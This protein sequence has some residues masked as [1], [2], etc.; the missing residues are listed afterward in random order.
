MERF[1][2]IQTIGDTFHTANL[3]EG[4]FSYTQ[5]FD[6]KLTG[7]YKLDIRFYDEKTKVAVLV[8]TKRQKS[9]TKKD[10]EQLFAYV[11]LEK[12]L[13]AKT[14]IIAI[15]T[16]IDDGKMRIWKVTTDLV[17]ELDDTK[18]KSFAEYVEYFKPQN[19][20][21]KTTV[22]ENTSRL[23]RLLH[24]KGIKENLRSQFVGTCLLALKNDLVYQNLSTPQIIAG[25]KGI[26]E[27][28]LD[29]GLDKAQKLTILYEKVLQNAN[30]Q[31]LED[32]D[33]SNLLT[34]IRER[35]L[36]YINESTK[37]GH[38][39]LSYFFTT[40]NKYVNREDKNQAF[41]PNHIAHFMCKVGGI[42]RKTRILDPTCGSGTFLVQAMTQALSCC[43]TDEERER[44]KQEQ[45]YGIEFDENVYGLA[46]T[47]MLIH[48]DGNSNIVLD[49]IAGCFNK[50][51]WIHNANADLVLMNPPYNASKAQV[52]KKFAKTWGK[53]T[54]DL[55]KAYFLCNT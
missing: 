20:N 37:E 48:G 16:N 4:G 46:T 39:I 23:N 15:L 33:F 45:I 38:D 31:N 13:S 18:I 34:F 3:E 17:E 35:I 55:P 28:M 5:V 44:V 2:I 26:L 10:V 21:D 54:T 52:T 24:D 22:L 40:F 47:N 41:T 11:A 12:E 8:E 9:L 50:E 19:I 51:R 1:Q 7:R 49:T 42:T 53:T 27:K 43:E 32:E 29:G 36:P 14:K 30:V 25:I 6:R